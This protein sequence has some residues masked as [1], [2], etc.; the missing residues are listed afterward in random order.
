MDLQTYLSDVAKLRHIGVSELSKPQLVAFK[1]QH[2][3]YM[4]LLGRPT[5]E[6]RDVAVAATAISLGAKPDNLVADLW[7]GLPVSEEN[8]F[9]S[10][11]KKPFSIEA[12]SKAVDMLRGCPGGKF[13][14]GHLVNVTHGRDPGD[15]IDLQV[16]FDGDLQASFSPSKTIP[17]LKQAC[18]LVL[19]ENPTEDV[20]WCHEQFVDIDPDGSMFKD[21]EG[22][23]NYL[24]GELDEVGKGGTVDQGRAG[25]AEGFKT[26]LKRFAKRWSIDECVFEEGGRFGSLASML[27]AARAAGERKPEELFFESLDSVINQAGEVEF[28][29]DFFRAACNHFNSLA[30]VDHKFQDAA[31]QNAKETRYR[32]GTTIGFVASDLD[33]EEWEDWRLGRIELCGQGAAGECREQVVRSPLE[34]KTVCFS[35]RMPKGK[36]AVA[37]LATGPDAAFLKSYRNGIQVPVTKVSDGGVKTFGVEF[38]VANYVNVEVTDEQ[39]VLGIADVNKYIASL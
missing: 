20:N 17:A 4:R 14:L 2:Q 28:T 39:F 7:S 12:V 22:F 32:D 24:I 25:Q 29:A 9:G 21:K 31:G 27:T 11:R 15:M 1:R 34:G 10:G 19:R 37:P 36:L 33:K 3:D 6:N 18:D 8:K 35:P 16:I 26:R 13:G 38:R 30:R 5:D 23:H